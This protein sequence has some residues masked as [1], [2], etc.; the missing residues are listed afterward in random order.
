MEH[1]DIKLKHKVQL[2]KKVEEQILEGG[3][4]S[5]SPK[6]KNLIW[7]I[8]AIIVLCLIVFWIF[9]KSGKNAEQETVTEIIEENTNGQVTA[10]QSDSATENMAVENGTEDE[11][12]VPTED[13]YA[14]SDSD[15]QGQPTASSDEPN[16]TVTASS[17]DPNVSDDVEAEAMK[18]IRGD[19][20]VGQERKD[21]LGAKYQTIQNRVNELKREGVF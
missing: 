13:A 11:T 20:G 19:Y 21:R 18:V 1:K 2:R 15:V 14:N 17:V 5:D 7:W 4:E 12:A 16:I 10:A 9:P 8:V 6:S 3:S